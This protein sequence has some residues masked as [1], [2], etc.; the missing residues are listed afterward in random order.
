VAPRLVID[1]GT[2][3]DYNECDIMQKAYHKLDAV[4]IGRRDTG[5]RS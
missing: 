4:S 2:K 5:G 3:F 1:Q